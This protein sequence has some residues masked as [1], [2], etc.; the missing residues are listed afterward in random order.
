MIF[1]F[2]KKKKNLRVRA[3]EHRLTVRVT[4]RAVESHSHVALSSLRTTG[5]SHYRRYVRSAK[6][7]F[8]VDVTGNMLGATESVSAS[9]A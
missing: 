1:F 9:S 2:K 4:L 8:V 7:Y 5:D 6:I 3:T